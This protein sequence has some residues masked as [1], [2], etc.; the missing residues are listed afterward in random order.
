VNFLPSIEEFE[1]N[2]IDDLNADRLLKVAFE[3]S[4]EKIVCD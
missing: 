2:L 4:D 1:K 3:Q